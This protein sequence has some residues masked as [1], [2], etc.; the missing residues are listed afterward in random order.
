MLLIHFDSLTHI[1]QHSK[2]CIMHETNIY[3]DKYMNIYN[4]Y[5]YRKVNINIGGSCIMGKCFHASR[6]FQIS[7]FIL[8]V[9]DWQKTTKAFE[10]VEDSF[11]KAENFISNALYHVQQ[12]KN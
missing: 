6:S 7:Y 9:P 2:N 8:S 5:I 11:R 12:Q 3:I 1:F 4:I 10:F